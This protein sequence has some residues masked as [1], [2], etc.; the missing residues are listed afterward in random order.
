MLDEPVRNDANGVREHYD[1]LLIATGSRA[2][3]PPIAGI[4][5]PDET[6][7]PGVFGFRTIDD[8]VA[9]VEYVKHSKRV[10]TVGGGFAKL[11]KLAEQRIN[12]IA[13]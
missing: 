6:L 10:V 12:R 2:F 13:A 4:R 8:C 5:R 11:T 3:I 9:M 1:K 7:K